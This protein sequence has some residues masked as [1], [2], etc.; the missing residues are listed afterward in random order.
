MRIILT[1]TPGTGKSAVGKALASTLGLELVDIK[2]IA[3]SAGLRA[4]NHEVDVKK[5]ARALSFLKTKKDFVAEGHLAAEIRLPADFVVVL[6]CRPR[7]LEKRL[8]RRK[9]PRKKLEDNLMAEMLDYCTQRVESIYGRAPLE[10]DTSKRSVL[11][12]AE[13]IAKAIRGRRKKIDSVDYSDSLKAFLE[14]R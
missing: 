13:E 7:I 2:K 14:I 10:L 9:Y 3:L 6:R 11:Q 12:A 4:K 1:G 5:L 8:K